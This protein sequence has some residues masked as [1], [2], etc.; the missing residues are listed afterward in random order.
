[1]KQRRFAK[2]TGNGFDFGSNEGTAS[3]EVEVNDLVDRLNRAKGEK[4][5]KVQR[6]ESNSCTC[7]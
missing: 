2:P 5:E 3:S 7:F 6:R 1:M 4:L